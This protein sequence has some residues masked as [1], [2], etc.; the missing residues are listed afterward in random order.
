MT[1]K[2]AAGLIASMIAATLAVNLFCPSECVPHC[3]TLLFHDA[4]RFSMLVCTF[5]FL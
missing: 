2:A 4:R 3:L 1:C 5:F